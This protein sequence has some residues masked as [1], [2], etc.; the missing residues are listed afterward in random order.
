MPFVIL[1]VILLLM[2][3]LD[4]GPV[5]SW[6]WYWVLA[7]FAVA[8]IWWEAIVPLIGWDKRQAAQKMQKD[9][10]EAQAWKKKTRGF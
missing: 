10:E 9:Q 1:G 5:G 7:P 3:L 6:K 8:F 4:I 2:W